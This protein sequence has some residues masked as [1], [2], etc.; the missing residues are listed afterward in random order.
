MLAIE[1]QRYHP[2]C[3]I[4]RYHAPESFQLTDDLWD[5]PSSVRPVPV[6]RQLTLLAEASAIHLPTDRQVC[7]CDVRTSTLQAQAVIVHGDKLWRSNSLSDSRVT[8]ERLADIPNIQLFYNDRRILECGYP[9]RLSDQ[10]GARPA[11]PNVRLCALRL[12][13]RSTPDHNVEIGPRHG[14]TVCKCPVPAYT[15]PDIVGLRLCW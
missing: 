15:L 1:F 2:G 10:E 13:S 7:I 14:Q 9:N 5:C 8:P 3:D 4:V 11:G 12:N 6:E